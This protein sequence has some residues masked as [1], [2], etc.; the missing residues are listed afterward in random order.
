M[1]AQK[2][3]PPSVRLMALQAAVDSS[4]ILSSYP[5]LVRV[6][7]SCRHDGDLENGL[8]AAELA[9]G[10]GELSANYLG[11]SKD[12]FTRRIPQDITFGIAFSYTSSDPQAVVEITATPRYSK[13]S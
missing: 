7:T 4:P 11:L 13:A 5:H 1:S 6:I 8:F 3:Q 2:I 9:T 10:L 12:I